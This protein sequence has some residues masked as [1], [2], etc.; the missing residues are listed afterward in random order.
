MA[1]EEA[2]E[3]FRN[4]SRRRFLRAASGVIVARH[5]TFA[6]DSINRRGLIE[7]HNPVL[8]RLDARSPLSV[9]NGEFAF[10]ADPTGLQS[11]PRFFEHDI[12]LCTLS[13]WG[14]HTQPG[15]A[16]FSAPHLRLTPYDT[17]GRQ[18]GYATSAEGQ[19]ELFNWLRENPHRLHLGR[20]GLRL[21][22]HDSAPSPRFCC[23]E[24][25]C[26]RSRPQ[27]HRRAS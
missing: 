13:Q 2:G 20:I 23:A 19:R 11:L 6:T 18:V 7:R 3:D 15:P 26:L 9:G 10:T 8:R 22:G 24:R 12:P 25:R 16:G 27:S 4:P 1:Q 17:Y 21:D 14:W 5:L